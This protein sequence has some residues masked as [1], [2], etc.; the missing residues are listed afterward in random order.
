MG[1]FLLQFPHSKDTKLS[2][3]C[4][5]P[6]GANMREDHSSHFPEDGE[7]DSLS[8]LYRLEL[9]VPKSQDSHCS[10][11]PSSPITNVAT[12]PSLPSNGTWLAFYVAL[13]LPSPLP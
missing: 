12:L 6:A 3:D 13:M 5:I 7:Q 8:V 2:R 10:L 11:T 4:L 9:K 1:L